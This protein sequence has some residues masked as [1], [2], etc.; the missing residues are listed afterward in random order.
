MYIGKIF[1]YLKWLY[2]IKGGYNVVLIGK[3]VWGKKE[4][5]YLCNGKKYY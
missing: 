1:F 4:N 3:S 2:K 5:F